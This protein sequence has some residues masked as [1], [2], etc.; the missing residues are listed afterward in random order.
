M[1]DDKEAKKKMKAACEAAAFR[2]ALPDCPFC[3][4]PLNL[5]NRSESFASV[6]V[7]VQCTG[8]KKALSRTVSKT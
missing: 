5:V 6:S 3:G 8:C 4:K 7:A 2:Q 1:A